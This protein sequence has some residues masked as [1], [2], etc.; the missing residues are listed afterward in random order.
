[1]ARLSP[2]ARRDWSPELTSFMV[3]YSANIKG[4][5]NNEGRPGAAN[6]VG[7][8]ARHPDLMRAFLTFN[9]H[10]LYGAT[11]T[12]RTRELLILRVAN[13][14]E[15][16]YEWAQHTL[17]A[18]DAGLTPEEISRVTKGP[19]AAGWS[20]IDRSLLRA[21]DELVLD[22]A[23]AESSWEDL[24]A[25]FDDRQLLDIVFTVCAYEL[26]AKV[27]RSVDVQPDPDLVRYLP[28]RN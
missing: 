19:D 28:V 27:L 12:A 14:R 15:S 2:I 6:L 10:L 1:M 18:G 11:I 20:A 7:T 8:F 21:A 16:D 3:D 25:E 23:V 17:L 9:G 26:L 22:G 4:E 24:A 13:L 5:R